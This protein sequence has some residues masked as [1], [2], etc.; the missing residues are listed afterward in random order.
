MAA[1]D[2]ILM[3]KTEKLNFEVSFYKDLEMMRRKEDKNQSS[4]NLLRF[5]NDRAAISPTSTP[6][7]L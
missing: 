4:M 3:R 5:S 1:I 7:H 6:I 2:F